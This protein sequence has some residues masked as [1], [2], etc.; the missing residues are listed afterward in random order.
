MTLLPVSGCGSPCLALQRIM[1]RVIL[2]GTVNSHWPSARSKR[3]LSEISFQLAGY[4]A[5][6]SGRIG[7]KFTAP[8][9]FSFNF[10]S[11][12]RFNRKMIDK[13]PILPHG[14]TLLANAARPYISHFVFLIYAPSRAGCFAKARK[15][16]SQTGLPL[17]LKNEES[18]PG[19]LKE[20]FYTH[21]PSNLLR[22]G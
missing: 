22:F 9:A 8:R 19:C 10:S 20:K 5:L 13:F 21:L 11:A 17:P 1:S 6:F 14:D 7:I 4:L 2:F 12:L 18:A 16:L 3:I 15:T